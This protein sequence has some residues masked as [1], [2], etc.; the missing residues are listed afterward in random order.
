MIR[1][2]ISRV[3]GTVFDFNAA[4]NK[5]FEIFSR[6]TK[7]FDDLFVLSIYPAFC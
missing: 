3:H 6:K 2:F 4:F 7:V 5:N 1:G